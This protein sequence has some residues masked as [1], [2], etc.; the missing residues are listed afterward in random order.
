M[1]GPL[2]EEQLRAATALKFASPL[3]GRSSASS[4]IL[5]AAARHHDGSSVAPLCIYSSPV[6]GMLRG[7]GPGDAA[8]RIPR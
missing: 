8:S 1:Q 4:Y 6:G 7:H 3:S 2:T 5:I